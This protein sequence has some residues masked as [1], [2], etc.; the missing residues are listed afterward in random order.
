MQ[1]LDVPLGIGAMW[2]VVVGIVEMKI[3][4]LDVRVMKLSK[5]PRQTVSLTYW[6]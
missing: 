5:Y 4:N 1:V 2:L 3:Q 6:E